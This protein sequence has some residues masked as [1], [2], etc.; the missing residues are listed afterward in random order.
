M[1][2][3]RGDEKVKRSIFIDLLIDEFDVRSKNERL[4]EL[5]SVIG[6][7]LK[8]PFNVELEAMQRGFVEQ[9]GNRE[10]TVREKI[11]DH[12][13]KIG[14]A[15]NG[16]EPNIQEWDEWG[17][18]MIDDGNRFKALITEWNNRLKTVDSR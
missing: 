11:E 9:L 10:M 3:V 4:L 16:V 13:K 8:E 7:A 5:F 15:G 17:D 18:S 1:N 6:S 2:G 12:L 14:I